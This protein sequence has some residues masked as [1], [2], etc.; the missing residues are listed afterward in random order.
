MSSA[1]STAATKIGNYRWLIC[2][3]LFFATTINYIDR[4]ALS[5]LKTTL[6]VLEVEEAAGSPGGDVPGRYGGEPFTAALERTPEITPS[7]R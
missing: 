1:P 6:R 2:A 4:N 5:V 7:A 3:L